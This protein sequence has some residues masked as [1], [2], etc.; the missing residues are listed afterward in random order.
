MN[1][2]TLYIIAS[3]I[4]NLEDIT[5]RALRVL[6]EEVGTV[7]CEDTRQTRKLLNHYGINLPTRSLHAHSDQRKLDEA[8]DLLMNGKNLAYL[9][10]SGT[11]GV[12]DPGGRF[13]NQARACDIPIIPLPGP[14]A[15]AALVSICGF[16]EKTVHFAGFLSKKDG[17]KKR[18]LER[19]SAAGGIII[20]YESPH[21]VKKTIKTLNE[22]FPDADIVIG[23][24]MTKLHEEYRAGT[25]AWIMESLDT[26]T[27]KGEFTLAIL[28]GKKVRARKAGDTEESIDFSEDEDP[29]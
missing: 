13:V 14:S 19:M 2:G 5:L 10:D 4:G 20:V 27:E 29:K 8:I 15:L 21:R 22:I 24:E 11:P 7:Y 9:T 18:E 17:R 25:M 16:P 23:R 6:R 28:P 26:L 12:S 1:K 3:P